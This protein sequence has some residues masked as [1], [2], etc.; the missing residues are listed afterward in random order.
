MQCRCHINKGYEVACR[1]KLLHVKIFRLVFY[2][3]GQKNPRQIHVIFFIP[4]WNS[5]R[6]ENFFRP[7]WKIGKWGRR[8][9]KIKISCGIERSSRAESIPHLIL[10]HLTPI[11]TVKVVSKFSYQGVRHPLENQLIFEAKKIPG[12]SMSFFSYFFLIFIHFSYFFRPRHAT[13]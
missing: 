7:V 10:P 3:W 9:E 6:S 4:F 13:S 1:Q 8:T 2:I 11:E 12:K 5:D